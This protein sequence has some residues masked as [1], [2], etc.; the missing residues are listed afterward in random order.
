MRYSGAMF[1]QVI[2][3]LQKLN[4]IPFSIRLQ[5]RC[6]IQQIQYESYLNECS[7]L[8]QAHSLGLQN[9]W[10]EVKKDNFTEEKTD[11]TPEIIPN[12]SVYLE[13]V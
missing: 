7:K 6:I 8:K 3:S 9:N 2:L 4:K 11:I 1:T 13:K 12:D 5:K 10:T